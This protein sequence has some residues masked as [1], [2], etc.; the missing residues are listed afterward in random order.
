MKES[1]YF[2]CTK[3]DTGDCVKDLMGNITCEF[4]NHYMECPVCGRFETKFCKDCVIADIMEQN[5]DISD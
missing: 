1:N 3:K 2:I 5:F 4:C